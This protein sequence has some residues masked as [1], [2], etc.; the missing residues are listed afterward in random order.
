MGGVF[1]ILM[2]SLDRVRTV[3]LA[4]SAIICLKIV[5]MLLVRG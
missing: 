2:F 1:T 3:L 4:V 5:W